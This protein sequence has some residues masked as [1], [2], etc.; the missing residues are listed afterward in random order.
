MTTALPRATLSYNTEARSFPSSIMGVNYQVSTWLPLGY[1]EANRKYPVIYLLDGETFFG[2]VSGIVSGLVWGQA[3]PDCLVV[4]VGH[5][6]NSL[7]EWWQARAVDLNP[8]ENPNIPCP[9]W[10]Q[11]YKNRRA[12]DFLRFFKNELIPFIESTYP[13]DPADRCLAGYSWGGQFAIYSLFHEPELFQKYFIGSGIWEYNLHDHLAYEEQ[14]ASQRKSLPAR[15]FF[16]VG[17]LEEDQLPY[18]PQFIEA[19]KC[20]NYDDFYLESQVIEGVNHG[21]GAAVAYIQG[22]RALYSSK[23]VNE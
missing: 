3:I 23:P 11:P 15:A 20:R 1:P 14:L 18:F 12:P 9:E 13:V 6:I 22:L 4:G 7:E 5:A 19:L 21:S 8:P 16:S 17:S 10:M 2:L